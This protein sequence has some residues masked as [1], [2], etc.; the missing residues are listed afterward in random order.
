MSTVDDALMRAKDGHLGWPLTTVAKDAHVLAGEVER[1]RSYR[2]QLTADDLGPALTA[3]YEAQVP[4]A[5]RDSLTANQV[6]EIKQDM[7]TSLWPGL[8][9]VIADI[10][11]R[12]AAL[13]G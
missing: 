8:E 6:R 2:L 5:V 1:M 7:L 10:N 11:A 9:V 12:L 13:R 3:I 4:A